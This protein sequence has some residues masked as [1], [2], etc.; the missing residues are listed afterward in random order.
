VQVAVDVV[1]L[2]LNVDFKAPVFIEAALG[3]DTIFALD[4]LIFLPSLI[5]PDGEEIILETCSDCELNTGKVPFF[6]CS[7]SNAKVLAIFIYFNF[8]VYD[9]Y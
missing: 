7:F 4:R 2:E 9:F 6:V 1:Q 8:E 5:S 3:R